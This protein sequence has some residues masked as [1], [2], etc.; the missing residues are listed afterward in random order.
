MS[1]H[2]HIS[3]RHSIDS[4]NQ[5]THHHNSMPRTKTLRPNQGREQTPRPD[6]NAISIKTHNEDESLYSWAAFASGL[7]AASA[8]LL[9]SV[10]SA[11]CLAGMA[12]SNTEAMEGGMAGVMKIG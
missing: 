6:A 10:H 8:T 3:S 9:A 7:E 11:A 1:N 4:V 5:T 2:D 12:V